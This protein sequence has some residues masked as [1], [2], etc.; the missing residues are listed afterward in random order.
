MCAW[1][2][3]TTTKEGQ[4]LTAYHHYH[5]QRYVELSERLFPEIAKMLG[6][7]AGQSL[8]LTSILE[9]QLKESESWHG[10]PDRL[11]SWNWRQILHK[12]RKTPKRMDVAF[13]CRGTLCGLMTAAIS[14]GKVAVNIRYLEANPDPS[15]PLKG[16]FLF[17]AL[18]QAEFFARFTNC[19]RVSVSQ[20]AE[21]LVDAY[22]S[23]EY[24][25]VMSDVKREARGVRPRHALLVKDLRSVFDPSGDLA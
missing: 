3:T 7:L 19:T 4:I 16:T 22:K 15:H 1:D 2:D 17:L 24:Q 13:Y 20:P 9:P 23:F 8:E 5:R 6:E 25:M 18:M 12:F 14:R 21:E 11:V 10:H